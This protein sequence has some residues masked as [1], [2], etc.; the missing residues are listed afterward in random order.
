LL[1]IAALKGFIDVVDVL[2]RA[3][4]DLNVEN[5]V[6]LADTDLVKNYSENEIFFVFPQDGH[7]P[8]YLSTENQL[9]KVSQVLATAGAKS[10]NKVC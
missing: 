7:T 3:R 4:V 6:L 2:V 8:L 5:Q 1:H 10:S 9:Y